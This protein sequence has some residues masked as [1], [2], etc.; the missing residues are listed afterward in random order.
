LLS[1]AKSGV[2]G[3]SSEAVCP[4]TSD[5]LDACFDI[6]VLVYKAYLVVPPISSTETFL[7]KLGA[8]IYSNDFVCEPFL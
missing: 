1:Q 2:F 7:K 4:D 5:S 8:I 3:Y 6:V